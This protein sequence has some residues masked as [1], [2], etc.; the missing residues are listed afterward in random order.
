[1]RRADEAVRQKW[2]LYEVMAT[3]GEHPE[4]NHG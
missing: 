2:D 3:R 1:M 4:T